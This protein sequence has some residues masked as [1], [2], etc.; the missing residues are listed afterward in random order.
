MIRKILATSILGI[1]QVTSINSYAVN[2]HEALSS[3]Y[4]NNEQIKLLQENFKQQVE[5]LP[6]AISHGFVPNVSANF[7][8]SFDK[9]KG[10]N[11][12][13]IIE[14]HDKKQF[15]K[16]INLSQNLFAGGSSVSAL[17][18]AK[19]KIQ[20][21]KMDFYNKEQQFMLDLIDIY[22]KTISS[23][24]AFEAAK[25]FVNVAQKQ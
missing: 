11:N 21:A 8:H 7:N 22:F 18:A 23:H 17:A 14:D 3:A 12:F 24:E 4:N 16:S 10:P 20:S 2:L 19:Y 1:M 6:N 13:G 5:V 25:A 9:G 15:E